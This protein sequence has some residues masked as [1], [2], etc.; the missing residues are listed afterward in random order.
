MYSLAQQPFHA[1]AHNRF[2]QVLASNETVPIMIEAVG[3]QPK[4]DEIRSPRF[5]MFTDL[6]ELG[7]FPQPL[8]FSHPASVADS[9][10]EP[11]A[12]LQPP[13]LQNQPTAPSCHARPKTVLAHSGNLLRLP[14]PLRHTSPPQSRRYYTSSPSPLSIWGL[15][16]ACFSTQ[17]S[18]VPGSWPALSS[19]SLESSRFTHA[20]PLRNSS[21]EDTGKSHL[22]FL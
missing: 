20:L 14:G 12:T 21:T 22:S 9:H 8:L 18:V 7:V 17:V 16:R 4:Y 3:Q 15:H 1:V 13:K 6:G 19:A 11:M 2:A 5:A 10:R